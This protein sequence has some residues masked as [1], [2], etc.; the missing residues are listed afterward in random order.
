MKRIALALAAIAFPTTTIAQGPAGPRCITQDQAAA[1]V[2]FALPTLVEGLAQHCEGVLPPNAY[3]EANARSLSSRFQPDADAAWPLARR[4]IASFFGQLLGQPMPDEMNSDMLRILAEPLLG[5]AL[6]KAV[7]KSDCVMVDAAIQS[8]APL[9][10]R[11]L[12]RLAAL[13]AMIADKKDKGIAGV[14][15]ICRPESHP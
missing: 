1:L 15:H 14:L 13:A 10:G 5:K 2:T 7:S 8:A 6:A 12:G 11:N 3:L 9:P 4:T